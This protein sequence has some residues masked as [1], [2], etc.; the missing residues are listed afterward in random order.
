[1]ILI[2][3]IK[4]NIVITA[5][6]LLSGELLIQNKDRIIYQ[7][8]LKNTN[9]LQI[10]IN[11]ESNGVVKINIHTQKENITKIINL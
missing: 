2:S 10:P 6:Y 11:L 5:D 7:T 4:P 9:D 1:M 3:F 8:T